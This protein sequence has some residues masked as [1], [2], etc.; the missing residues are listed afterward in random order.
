M[1]GILCLSSR[2]DNGSTTHTTL[3]AKQTTGNT[4][5]SRQNDAATHKAT[6]GG[7]GV[8]STLDNERKGRNDMVDIYEKNI[9][10]SQHIKQSH[11]GNKGGTDT[12]NTLDTKQNDE[13]CQDSNTKPYGPLGNLHGFVAKH[14]DGITLNH[15]ANTE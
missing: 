1:D 15:I 11:K 10:T 8:K 14:G 12:R 7:R 3:V 9:Q 6:T 4:I 13:G 5:A 2:G